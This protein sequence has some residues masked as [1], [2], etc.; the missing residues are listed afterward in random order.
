[1]QDTTI[2]LERNNMKQVHEYTEEDEKALQELRA[3][4]DNL[5]KC[6]SGKPGESAEKR[7][8][9]AYTK[10]YRL[11]LKQYPPRKS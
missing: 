8:L 9:E 6:I 5:K 4:S 2:I 7:Y 10:C 11:G 1:M 3:A